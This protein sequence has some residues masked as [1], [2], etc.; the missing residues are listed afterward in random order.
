MKKWLTASLAALMLLSSVCGITACG[1]T[2]EGPA[3]EAAQTASATEAAT[4]AFFPDVEKTDYQG[5]VFRII[6]LAWPGSWYYAEEMSNEEGGIH[7]LNNTIYEMNTLVEDHLGIEMEYEFIGTMVTGGE[8]FDN[9]QPTIMSGDD[10]YQLCV[11]HPYYS[12]NSFISRDYA[13]DFYEIPYLDLSQ[14]YWN[15]EVM[16]AL[17]VGGKAYIGLGDICSYTLNMIYCNKD[18]LVQANREVPYEQVRNGAWTLDEFFGMTSELYIDNG[19][20]KR[21]NLDTYGFTGLWDANGSA[22]MQGC[23]IYVVTRNEDEIYELS[24]YGDRLI[25]MYD[26]L[27]E[28]SKDESTYIWDFGHRADTAT[29]VDFLDGRSYFTHGALG[30]TYLESDFELGML[31]QPKFDTAQPEYAHVN[32]G[33]NIVL[34]CTIKNKAMVG[35]ALELMAFYS[36]TM[37]QQKYYDEVLQLRV[38]EA[39]D[40][41]DMVELIYSTVVFDPGIAYC[42]GHSQLWNLV[43]LPCFGITGNQPNVAS[44]Y[45]ANQRGAERSLQR[46]FGQ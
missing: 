13:L 12:Y 25:T 45:K 14:S 29:I 19:D 21:N 20:G 41:R 36:K 32:W 30:T 16:D 2:T 7:I 37:V 5:E 31:P 43:Y 42:D 8:I 18:L 17:E 22:F 28:W 15:A 35:Q 6:S 10:V 23:G 46:I 26:K 3:T 40:D 1:T 11:L 9:V 39:P 27:Y 38:S 33:H 34:P 4:E 24:L 44:Y